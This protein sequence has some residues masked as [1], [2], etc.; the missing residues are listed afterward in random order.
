MLI[1]VSISLPVMVVLY[2]A[3]NELFDAF[4]PLAVR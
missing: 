2:G 3:G 4:R 1:G